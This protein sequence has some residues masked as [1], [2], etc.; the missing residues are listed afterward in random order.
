MP[1]DQILR[2]AFFCAMSVPSYTESPAAVSAMIPLIQL[3]DCS[4]IPP[5]GKLMRLATLGVRNAAPMPRA[6]RRAARID[7][8][9]NRPLETLSRSLTR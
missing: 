9:T 6:P 5:V 1:F 7:R 4:T 2:G 3:N 8:I